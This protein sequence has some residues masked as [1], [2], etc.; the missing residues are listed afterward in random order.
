MEDLARELAEELS[1]PGVGH[2]VGVGCG[3]GREAIRVRASGDWPASTGD[4]VSAVSSSGSANGCAFVRTRPVLYYARDPAAVEPV[5]ALQEVEFD[6]EGQ[7]DDLAL[8][9]FDELDVP[10]TVPPV[11]SRSSTM[12]TFWPG[13]IASRWT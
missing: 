10:F 9:A 12:S 11:A 3:G 2:G 6:E 1:A 8:E 5:A 13:L 4:G 7:S